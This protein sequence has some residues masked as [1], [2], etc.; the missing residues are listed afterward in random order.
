MFF[1]SQRFY[2]LHFVSSC[3][4]DCI[5]NRTNPTP[6]DGKLFS[7]D[8]Q[9]VKCHPF[10][11]LRRF[12]LQQNA[13][14]ILYEHACC[15]FRNI[16][17]NMVSRVTQWNDDGEGRSMFLDRHTVD[18]GESSL[19]HS[20][21]L[22]RD[23]TLKQIRYLYSCCDVL[24]PVWEIEVKCQENGNVF[25][26]EGNKSV[27]ILALQNVSCDPGS[28]LSKFVYSRD[29]REYFRYEYKCCKINT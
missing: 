29:I 8:K 19:L 25:M 18:C 11:L 14:G 9:Q 23:A 7:L 2:V 24:N 16:A 15:K 6:S 4:L 27:F 21:V 26:N 5:D 20:F 13:T 17:C 22:E 3:I 10:G 12:Q 1:A 28:A